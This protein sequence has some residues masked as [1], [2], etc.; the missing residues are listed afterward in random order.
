MKCTALAPLFALALASGAAQ[1]Q[2]HTPL[3]G[4]VMGGGGAT[5]SGGGDDMTIAYSA[6]GAGGGG[7]LS[8]P[9]RLARFAGG[10]G[11]GQAV[12]YWPRRQPGTAARRGWWAAATAP[13][14]ST[15]DAVDRPWPARS[16]ARSGSRETATALARS[17]PRWGGTAGQGRLSEGPRPSSPRSLRH[18]GLHEPLDEHAAMREAVQLPVERADPEG[19]PDPVPHLD[20]RPRFI[21]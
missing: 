7:V 1:A 17:A 10:H 16:R 12:E 20:E 4:N 2:V 9:G 8:Q 5:V 19:R 3:G 15:T 6:G 18:A 21:G 13:R 14:W 11:D